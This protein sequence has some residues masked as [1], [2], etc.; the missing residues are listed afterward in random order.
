MDTFVIFL[1]KAKIG[2]LYSLL[3]I[4]INIFSVYFYYKHHISLG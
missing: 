4:E 2:A 3:C 1:T